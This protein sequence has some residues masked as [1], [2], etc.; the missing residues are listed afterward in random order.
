[1]ITWHLHNT[2]K[3]DPRSTTSTIYFGREN[4]YALSVNI[5]LIVYMT[6]WPIIWYFVG[7]DSNSW[8]MFILSNFRTFN[9][10][11]L[12]F[13]LYKF[14]YTAWETKCTALRL[15]KLTG[16]HGKKA[17]I[18]PFFSPVQQIFIL[19]TLAIGDIFHLLIHMSTEKIYIPNFSEIFG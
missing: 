1:M 12:F 16:L 8:I 11:Y 5:V 10:M 2:A 6:C 15:V 18:N 7:N 14:Y 9:K 19:F 13:F 3:D 4:K 17:R